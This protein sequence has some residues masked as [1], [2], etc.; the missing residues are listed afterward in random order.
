[1]PQ[2]AEVEREDDLHHPVDEG[3]QADEHEE[4][5]RLVA[6]VPRSPEGD[7]SRVLNSLA[8]ALAVIHPRQGDH[9]EGKRQRNTS[10]ERR[11]A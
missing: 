9:H 10:P 7:V 2:R 5:H 8:Q 4:Q 1:M 11:R 3:A 6:E